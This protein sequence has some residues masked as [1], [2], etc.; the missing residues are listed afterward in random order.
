M[1]DS[2]G[3]LGT[4]EITRLGM[5]E[6]EMKEL[7]ELIAQVYFGDITSE[8][9]RRIRTLAQLFSKPSYCF[10]NYEEILTL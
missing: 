4:A 1:V 10:D 9:E 8:T 3:R 7:A 2:G 6:L 5:K